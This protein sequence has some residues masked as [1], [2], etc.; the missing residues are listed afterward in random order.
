[1][2]MVGLTR[3]VS[4]RFESHCDDLVQ[5]FKA[6]KVIGYANWPTFC[7]LHKE[8]IHSKSFYLSSSVN[9]F[10]IVCV[11]LGLIFIVGHYHFPQSFCSCRNCVNTAFPY[12]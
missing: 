1:M 8:Y 7:F 9:K 4:N 6:S 10:L 11:L 12:F 5:W 2:G 3:Y